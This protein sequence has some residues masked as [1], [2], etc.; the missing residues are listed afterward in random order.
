[1][2]LEAE[3]IAIESRFNT[4]WTTTTKAFDNIPFKPPT[5]GDGWARLTILDGKSDQ[6]SLNTDP[7][8]RRV[9]VITVQIFVPKGTGTITV[10]TYADSIAAIFRNAVFSG[11]VCRSP[12]LVRV[13]QTGEWY[14]MNV[15]VPFFI[16]EIF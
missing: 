3:R 5:N 8:H 1:M 7:T 13:G 6:V 10:R 11:I 9:G 4:N 14:Q 16:D 15:I 2:T 12:F